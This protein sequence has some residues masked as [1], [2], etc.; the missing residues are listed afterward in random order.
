MKELNTKDLEQVAGG[1]EWQGQR[2]STNVEDMRACTPL[3]DNIN[4]GS[5]TP[6][7]CD[8]PRFTN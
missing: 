1:M 3:G 4:P 7:S 5:G 2:E 6:A 8:N